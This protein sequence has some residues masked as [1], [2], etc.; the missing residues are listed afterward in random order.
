MKEA[1]YLIRLSLVVQIALAFSAMASDVIAS[2]A[3]A[4]LAG[5]AINELTRAVITIDMLATLPVIVLFVATLL[6]RTMSTRRGVQVVLALMIICFT[7]QINMPIVAATQMAI[8]DAI[9]GL[10]LYE[11]VISGASPA[12]LVA[13]PIGELL[14][15]ALLP[16][17]IGSWLG[18]KRSAIG[19]V[20]FAS[21]C[22]FISVLLLW[23]ITPADLRG[24]DRVADA[25][26]LLLGQSLVIAMVCYFVGVLADQQRAEQTQVEL[27]NSQLAE[28]N[29]Q[30]AAQASIREQLAA[31]RERMQLSRELHDTLAHTLAGL[32]VQLDAVSAIIDPEDLEVK[33]ELARASEL[34]HNGLDTA[35]DAVVGLR[36][37]PVSELGLKQAIQR[38]LTLVE[39]RA[40][41]HAELVIEAGEPNIAQADAQSLYG[42]VQEALNNVERHAN[43]Q[44][45]RVSLAPRSLSVSDDGVGFDG[46]IPQNGR[47]GLRGMRERA[48]SMNARLTVR[49]RAGEGTTIEVNW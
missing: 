2:S 49:S 7:W 11:I 4:S 48:A 13:G 15:F 16:A 5:R 19:W 18:G 17:V 12:S 25:V 6:P 31:S 38:Q 14:L 8:N 39:R 20:I 35:R 36:V 29:R 10:P 9:I 41:V 47:Y 33:A 46:I 28:A 42:I 37:D 1:K 40:N 45:V 3:E 24:D 26:V 22:S 30:L 34:A 44:H 43:A 32:A 27:A 21:T 23:V